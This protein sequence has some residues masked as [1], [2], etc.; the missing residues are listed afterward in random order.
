MTRPK[1]PDDKRQRTAQACDTCKRRKQKC[2][3][4]RPC[5]T[6]TKRSLQCTYTTS[7][8]SEQTA[9][10]QLA[11]PS[12]RRN[13]EELPTV[14]P[15]APD[16]SLTSESPAAATTPWDSRPNQPVND[17]KPAAGSDIKPSIEQDHEM[18]GVDREF[19]IRSRHSTASGPDE[20]TSLMQST[21]MLQDPTGRLLYVGDSASLAYLQLIRMIVEASVG[22]SDFTLDPSRH[23]IMEATSAIPD[24]IRPPHILP[25]RD[26]ANALL[27]S[28]FTNT[29][30]LIEV[31][32]RAAFEESVEA[33]YTDPLAA[34]SSFLCLLHLTLAIGTVLGTPLP[35][36]KE[37]VIFKKLRA[38]RYDRAELFFRSAKALGDPIS[39]FED[40][41]FW[42]VQALSLMAV[43]MLAISKRNA[44]YAYFGMA[45][46]SGFA[47]GLHRVHEN[48]FIFNGE[49]IRLRRNLWRS[50]FVLDRFLAASLG[51]PVAIDEEECSVDALLVFEKNSQGE[52]I[53]VTDPDDGLDAAVRSCRIVGQILK[54][55]YARRRISVRLAQEIWEQCNT[56]YTTLSP[57]LAGGRVAADP[58]NPAQGIAALHVNLLYCHSILLLTR[59]F[60]LCLLSKVHGERSGLALPVPR[61]INRM[62][63]YCEACLHASNQTI[64]YVQKAFESNY[65]PQR[66]PFVLYFLFAASLVILS[67]EFASIYPNP[68]YAASISNTIAIMRY[69]ATSDPQAGRL[70]FI[71]TSF[72]NVVYELQQKK[73]EQPAMPAPPMLSP[74]SLNDPIGTI[75]KSSRKN[76]LAATVSGM[77]GNKAKPMAPP[78][79]SMK[80]DHS[81]PTSTGPSAVASPAG[82]TPSMSQGD[83]SARMGGDSDT[84]DGELEFDQLWGWSAVPNA[85]SR[86]PHALGAAVPA[87]AGVPPVAVAA[88]A[89]PTV[90]AP[91]FSAQGPGQQQFQGFANY[92]VPGG[93][94]GAGVPAAGPPGYTA[95]SVPMYVPAEYS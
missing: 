46:R 33:C 21:R 1:V 30:G 7:N 43:Y 8:G 24:S 95:P 41:D 49:E 47:L 4:A 44:A 42:S 86:G 58:S 89:A 59:P 15:T 37:D 55:I 84:G 75:F 85:I 50:L 2:N 29:H 34:Q 63:K 67:N 6:C 45:V 93:P 94:N 25:D 39:G 70:L 64:I 81:F 48:H 22:P 79:L 31:F 83:Q 32:N 18:L 88:V 38:S 3:G 77:T 76:S 92:V 17:A 10:D 54:K 52:L 40:A 11:S 36:S 78:P 51:R 5:G 26:T 28:F 35:G 71:L 27:D 12:K 66:N 80:T 16:G 65:L 57:E 60:F 13:I 69:C 14:K 20:E 61:W 9:P 72:R 23:K 90:N 68:T 82:S 62:S 56:W 74:T 19:D 53:R 87:G 91:V 73:T